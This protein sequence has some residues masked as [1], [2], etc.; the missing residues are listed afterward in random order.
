MKYLNTRVTAAVFAFCSVLFMPLVSSAATPAAGAA[1][2]QQVVEQVAQELFGLVKTKNAKNTADEVYFQQVEE[3]L[4]GV[5]NFQYIAGAVMGKEPF[6]KATPAQRGE[7]LKVFRAGLVKSYAKGIAGYADSDIKLL[8]VVKDPKNP[9]RVVV[10]QEVSKEGTSH[11]LDYT[12]VQGKE[13]WKLINVVLNGVNL[14]QSFSG[15][16][17][18]ALKK[19]GGDLDKV[20]ANWLADA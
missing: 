10:K 7:F 4:D 6:A 15:Q 5:V 9:K 3:I 20:I 16:F 19:Q 17:K 1:E 12:M 2:P 18:A 14:G 11:K 13:G 8:G